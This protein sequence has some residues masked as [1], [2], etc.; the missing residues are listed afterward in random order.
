MIATRDLKDAAR[1]RE[2][3]LLDV[4]HPGPIHADRHRI[5]GLARHR[6]RVT[7]DAFAIVDYEA[8]FHPPKGL[9]QKTNNHTWKQAESAPGIQ[10]QKLY[11]EVRAKIRMR[12]NS[13]QARMIR[14][15]KRRGRLRIPGKLGRWS[16]GRRRPA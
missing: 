16:A 12:A 2:N 9:P 6:A 13:A 4:F 14:G 8:V 3:A 11:S 1:V 7:S 15:T 10:V 5:L